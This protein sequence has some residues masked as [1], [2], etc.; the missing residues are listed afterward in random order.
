MPFPIIANPVVVKISFL[1]ASKAVPFPKKSIRQ[2]LA[3]CLLNGQLC[4][5]ESDT[6][7]GAVAE[8]LVH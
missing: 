3:V 2:L 8:G 1:R 4:T 6:A 7:V 5:L